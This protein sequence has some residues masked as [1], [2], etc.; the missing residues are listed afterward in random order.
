MAWDL[1]TG[2]LHRFRDHMV[3]LANGGYGRAFF[4]TTRKRSRLP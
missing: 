3:V 2:S 4:S 1:E